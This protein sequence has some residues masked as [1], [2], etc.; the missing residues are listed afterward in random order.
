MPSQAVMMQSDPEAMGGQPSLP[1]NLDYSQLEFDWSLGELPYQTESVTILLGSPSDDDRLY[2]ATRTRLFDVR[3]GG[4]STPSQ[5]D[6]YAEGLWMPAGARVLHRSGQ[7]GRVKLDTIPDGVS[8]RGARRGDR[9]HLEPHAAA[10]R[11][12]VPAQEPVADLARSTTPIRPRPSRVAGD[13]IR[14]G[15]DVSARGARRAD[16]TH[17][18]PLV[19]NTPVRTKRSARQVLAQRTRCRRSSGGSDPLPGHCA[20]KR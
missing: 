7:D 17:A 19:D 6:L 8:A 14:S 4:L 15:G 12:G 5:V 3:R 13:A 2:L 18:G 11:R 20:M 10:N 9:L 1:A 16:P